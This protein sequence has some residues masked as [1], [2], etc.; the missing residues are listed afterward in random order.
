MV[1]R[2]MAYLRHRF[3]KQPP[4]HR[5]YE[6]I[7]NAAG[8]VVGEWRRLTDDELMDGYTPQRRQPPM[9]FEDARC[10]YRPRRWYEGQ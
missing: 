2:L 9:V 3:R 10:S 5:T 4:V 8:E 6:P 7:R 1:R